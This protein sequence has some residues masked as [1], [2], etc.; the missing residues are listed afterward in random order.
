MDE[1]GRR[2]AMGYG[3]HFVRDAEYF[4]WRYLDSPR[5]Y[6]C[7]G[8]YRS[9]ELVGVAVVGHTFKHGVS[10]GFLADLVAAP[11]GREETRALLSRALAEVR[12][13]ADALVLLPPPSRTQ[14]RALVRAGFA[15]TN[16]K[17][18]FIGK[19]LHD[20]VA[21]GRARRRVALHARRLRLLLEMAK[22]VFITQ[23]VD[24]AHPALAATVPKLRALARLVDEVVVLA[25]GAVDDVLPSNCRVRTF[26]SSRKAGRGVRFEAA[27]TRELR[28]LRGGAVVAHMCPIYAVLAAPLIRPLRIP[29]VLWFTHWKASRLLASGREGLDGGHERGPALIPARIGEGARDRPRDRPV[30]VSVRAPACGRRAAAP[31]ARAL[32]DGEGSGRHSRAH[33]PRARRMSSSAFTGRCSLTR[34]VSTTASSSRSSTS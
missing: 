18:R 15:P 31:R 6:R 10:A 11:D 19:P 12:G 23:Q 34:S 13:G 26:R 8:A 22:V 2:A 28:G 7:F 3:S 32:L 17:L 21:C 20:G 25:D 5:D 14:R 27:L 29:L 30:G 24:P 33:L 4:N 16:K 1:L 9:R